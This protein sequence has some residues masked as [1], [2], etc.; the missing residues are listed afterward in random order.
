MRKPLVAFLLGLLS[1]LVVMLIGETVGP[2]A[3]FVSMGAY[4]F[5]CQFLLSRGN[6]DANREDWPIM[7]A[8]NATVLG[9]VLIMVLVEKREV[10]LSQGPGM[11]LSACGGTYAGAVAASLIARRRRGKGTPAT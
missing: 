5:I 3:A 7:L 2:L 1:F 10:V 11:L 9:M 6:I 4:F 8:L